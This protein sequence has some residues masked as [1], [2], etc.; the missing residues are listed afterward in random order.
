MARIM[1]PTQPFGATGHDST[2][3]LF[4]AAAFS[5]ESTAGDA[6]RVL[7]FLLHHGVNHIDTAHSYGNGNSEVLIGAWMAQHR[8]RFFLA[9][10]T[11]QRT[12]EG[13]RAQLELSR[14]RLR[15][16]T[17]DLIQLHNL[18]DE[19]AWETA[20]APGGALAELVAARERGSVRFI[21]VTGH[22]L[23]TPRMHLRSLQR[24]PFDAVL[25]PMNYV[26]ASNPR[27]Y[28]D[29][30]CLRA[31]CFERGVAVQLIKTVARRPWAG[32][33]RGRGPWY[34]PLD[35]PAEHRPRRGLRREL[36]PCLHQH[37]GRPRPPAA[38]PASRRGPG[39]APLRRRNGRHAR[40]P[41]HAADLRGTRH[42]P[43][44]RTEAT[45]SKPRKF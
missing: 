6:D 43:L 20:M 44:T 10:K 24:F 36:R 30:M 5:P 27:Y 45:L 14:R 29:F 15:S 39:P 32:R 12:A 2:L 31:L 17:I 19:Q 3:T 16:D 33:P 7:E 38:G 1:I 18:T 40:R 41:G 11:N 22:G 21:G 42:H 23:A 25:L 4:G 13:A 37:H 34:E 26:L 9:T 8:D 35:S 28:G